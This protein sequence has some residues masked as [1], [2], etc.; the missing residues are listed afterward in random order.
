MITEVREARQL[1]GLPVWEHTLRLRNDGPGPVTVTRAD[2]LELA[3][4]GT[5]STLAFTS[6]WGQEGAPVRSTTADGVHL[7]SRSGRSSHGWHPWLGLERGG[8]GLIV[9]PAWSGNWHIDLDDGVLT[10][11]IS[12]WRFVLELAPGEEF[13]APS[14]VVATGVTMDDAAVLLSTAIGRDWIPRSTASDRLDVEWNHWWPYEDAEV[15]EEVIAQ[16]AALAGGL[17]I[18]VVT[19]DAGWFGAPGETYWPDQRGDWDAVNTDRFPSGLAALGAAIRERGPRAGIWF[20]GEAVGAKATLRREHPELLALTDEPRDSSY[21][22]GTVSLDA[23]D[24]S[25]LGYLC[26]GAPAARDFVAS[27]LDR[28]VEEVGAEWIKLDFN[29]DP[30]SGC[31]RTDHGHGE[32]DG[33]LRHYEG[34]YSVLDAFRERHPEVVLEACS[35]GGLRIDLGLARHVHCM[36][37]SDPD[38]TEHALQVLWAVSLMLPPVGMLHWSWSQWRGDHEPSKLDF[39]ALGRDAFDTILRAA[40]LHRFGISMRL[41]EL[42]EDQLAAIH[43]H[44]SLFNDTLAPFVRDGNLHRLTAQPLRAG[45]GERAPA[46]ELVLGERSIVAAF[47]LPGGTAPDALSTVGVGARVTDLATG[48]TWMRDDTLVRLPAGPSS[49][50]FLIEP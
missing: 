34:L 9:S 2:A 28:L 5:W 6:S 49:W 20:E 10:A 24:P 39:A 21:G 25:F 27:A 45:E 43:Q 35:S 13:S 16:N 50:L 30:D 14:V 22:V 23:D 8:E 4:E 3:L 46:F 32:G 48:A 42:S 11:G 17:G 18:R 29:V 1:A 47:V 41:P 37:L 12:P 19:V 40:M 44:V 26:L 38:Y 7:E 15:T 31:T 36:F 33:L